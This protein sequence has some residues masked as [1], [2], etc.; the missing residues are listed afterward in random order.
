YGR[1]KFDA[2]GITTWKYNAAW[3][4]FMT[5][6]YVDWYLNAT[7]A[8]YGAKVA[9]RPV[10]VQYAYD[11]KSVYVVNNRN[12]AQAGLKVTARI[13][14][15][16]MTEQDAWTGTVDVPA[17]GV[18]RAVPIPDS[19]ER[20]KSHFLKLTLEDSS[21]TAM[22]S[23]FYWLSTVPD[24]PDKMN[25]D[26]R[27]FSVSPKSIADHTDLNKLPKVKLDV[28]NEWQKQGEETIA[29]VTLVNPAAHL[30]FQIHLA[31]HKGED[32]DEVCPAYWDENYLSL[33]PGEQRT[34]KGVFAT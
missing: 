23:N 1:N 5:W 33:L 24:I 8:Y 20:T 4:A 27:T 32:G 29:K 19:G 7:G 10:H 12:D 22:D 31:V 15:D 25:R 11:D 30:A 9:C 34:I 26:W 18:A 13:I 28:A 14:N 6:H 17:N 16:D 21:G 3:P 2:C